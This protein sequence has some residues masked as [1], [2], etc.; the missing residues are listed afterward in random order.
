[1]AGGHVAC[2]PHEVD[3]DE[4]ASSPTTS[5]T[6]S[7]HQLYSF[8][9]EL[10][11]PFDPHRPPAPPSPNEMQ[12]LFSAAEQYEYWLASPDENASIG[13]SLRSC[14]GPCCKK[15]GLTPWRCIEKPVYFRIAIEERNGSSRVLTGSGGLIA[16]ASTSAVASGQRGCNR[17]CLATTCAV[18]PSAD[19]QVHRFGS[20]IGASLCWLPQTN[21]ECRVP[22]FV[23]QTGL[24]L[25]WKRWPV[26]HFSKV[27]V[28]SDHKSP[29][30]E[31][32]GV[33]PKVIDQHDV[34][35]LAD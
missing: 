6:V 7:K 18:A 16:L 13:I 9:R 4:V 33:L 15:W 34:A 5:I 12:Q 20:S 1:V 14:D 24:E 25:C 32:A 26:Y 35:V 28:P 11:R 2:F 17:R 8:F 30:A 10:A 21:A 3:T 31:N 23:V 19:S 22:R 29:F 27:P